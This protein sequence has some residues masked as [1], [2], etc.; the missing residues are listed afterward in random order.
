MDTNKRKEELERKRQ[1]LAELK[2]AR[3]ERKQASAQQSPRPKRSGEQ[4]STGSVGAAV[5]LDANAQVEQLVAQLVSQHVSP[6]KSSDSKEQLDDNDGSKNTLMPANVEPQFQLSQSHSFEIKPVSKVMYEKEIQTST[7]DLSPPP[8][9]PLENAESP[10]AHDTTVDEQSSSA[11]SKDQTEL[12]QVQIKTL[13]SERLKQLQ[14]SSNYQD[15]L[16]NATKTVEKAMRDDF[17]LFKDYTLRSA[18]GSQD[19]ALNDED[20]VLLNGAKLRKARISSTMH[21]QSLQQSGYSILDVDLSPH[22][23]ELSLASYSIQG[24]SLYSSQQVS[25]SQ[26]VSSTRDYS[27]K[28]GL[29][30]V[31]NEHMNDVPEFTFTSHHEVSSAKFISKHPNLVVGG[32]AN[33]QV[34][35]WD[36]RAGQKAV[37]QS[38]VC[39]NWHADRICRLFLTGSAS[40]LQ[41][42]HSVSVDGV[43]CSWQ[44]DMLHKPTECLQL[45]S[46]KQGS[47]LMSVSSFDIL[48]GDDTHFIAGYEQGQI[49]FIN[50]YDQAGLKAG[51][52]DSETFTPHFGRINSIDTFKSPH[53]APGEL[54]LAASSDQTLSLYSLPSQ[55]PHSQAKAQNAISYDPKISMECTQ[56]A[57]QDARWSPH[58]PSVFATVNEF[59]QLDI[60]NLL[61]SQE[62]P[63]QS[64]Q[65]TEDQS[66]L[67]K[68]TWELNGKHCVVGGRNAVVSVLCVA[69][70]AKLFD[71]E[72]GCVK[73]PSVSDYNAIIFGDMKASSDVEGKLAVQG[74]AEFG[75]GFS[76]GDK[77]QNVSAC[78]DAVTVTGGSLK[79]PNGRNYFG[80]IVVGDNST[81]K[82]ETGMIMEN[83]CQVLENPQHFNFNAAWTDVKAMSLELSKMADTVVSREVDA[84][85]NLNLT[86]GGQRMVECMNVADGSYLGSA[87]KSFAS[88]SGIKQGVTIVINIAGTSPVM[89]NMDQEALA[90]FNVIFNFYQA[91]TIQIYGIAVRG[92]V[93]APLA[94]GQG[95]NGVV[96]GPVYMKSFEGP[97][98]I[99]LR[100]LP[101][102][103]PGEVSPAIKCRLRPTP[104]TLP[105]VTT[106]TSATVEV[107]AATVVNQTPL[108]NVPAPGYG[109]PAP[110]PA[111]QCQCAQ[112]PSSSSTKATLPTGGP[113]Y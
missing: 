61:F 8:Q 25:L 3:E 34:V 15:F 87:V 89:A 103:P 90:G 9:S 22:F 27:H 2:K 105:L 10:R 98:Q 16:I 104:E 93:V 17:D 30:L 21:N 106:T 63:I 91:T 101:S 23:G 77:L 26:S 29:V 18:G 28:S 111:P 55:R 86:F 96:H 12:G 83:G 38:P 99:N 49:A 70:N 94:S 33:G 37:L 58:N 45:Q 11:L 64:I 107:A 67:Y 78:S 108:P 68:L 51:I 35:I 56:G 62:E 50:R 60:W 48:A 19:A 32:L 66:A 47:S 44:V 73:M 71:T 6:I 72:R 7:Q 80:N 110:V 75:A 42:I 5:S 43:F 53:T 97:L 59:G 81:S 113:T 40:D 54:V 92:A 102:C 84:L 20:F 4:A 85:L 41:Q 109:A 74:N 39:A 31:W 112:S 1:K 52:M 79:W 82:I 65:V 100:P 36:N 76:V 88:V 95:L 46:S 57:V 69:S 13:D 14:S 24:D